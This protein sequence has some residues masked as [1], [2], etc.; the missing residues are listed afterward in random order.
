LI[1]LRMMQGNQRS[2]LEDMEKTLKGFFSELP[3]RVARTRSKEI[4]GICSF[5]D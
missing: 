5:H 1:G 4:Q 2:I 3:C